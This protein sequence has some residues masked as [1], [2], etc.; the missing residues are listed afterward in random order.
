[1]KLRHVVGCAIAGV[2]VSSAIALA[3]P[4]SPVSPAAGGALPSEIARGDGGGGAGTPWHAAVGRTLTMDA[5]LG[6]ASL[7]RGSN[8]E[9]F[10]FASVTG[11]D[12]A[13]RTAPP[14]LDLA[15]VV[16]RSGSMRGVRMA[17]ATAAAV[18]AVD[19]MRDGDSVVVVAFDTRADVVVP[20]TIVDATT[21]SRIEAAVRGIR[22]GGDTC[23]SCGL[24][25]A[26]EQ[27]GAAGAGGPDRVTRVMLL[28]DGAT[29]VGVRDTAGLRA[30]AARVREQ[31]SPIT[32][33]GVDVGFDERVMGALASESNGNHYFVA[34]A[35]QLPSVFSQEFDTLVA[36][37]AR[38]AELVVEPAPGVEIE[39]VFDR[40]FR[41]E[42][43]RVVV[44]LGTFSAKD[45]KS[46][47]LKVRVP[48]D[49]DGSVPVADVKLAYR[50]LVDR[51][52]ARFDAALALQVTS[53]ED[54]QRDLDP[55]VRARVERSAT[56]RTL[57]EAN[58]LMN[59]GQF[60]EAQRRLA[61]RAADLHRAQVAAAETP[62]AAAAPA[63]DRA[64]S[65]DKDFGD[66]AAALDDANR[67]T[68]QA[69]T[70]KG[71]SRER[72][73]APKRL[74]ATLESNPFR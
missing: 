38:D 55:F 42:G 51:S 53:A 41:R 15:I 73:A 54:S 64:R 48:A 45:E 50:D 31:G 63:P 74:E 56:A 37:V 34:D 70:T 43:S 2:L 58:E 14:P 12:G 25:R 6:H 32:T 66:Q 11:V 36:S 10:L 65:F 27:L 60:D 71:D 22:L 30:L 9:T 61:G 23:I 8:G 33:I 20:R 5:R 57:A 62:A 7:A 13:A 3:L 28:S 44:P 47:L 18:G 17:N 16:D 59:A 39:Q 4:M 69:S 21:R 46:L 19:R 40:A 24:E 35:S 52:D 67:V 26:A 1:M 72:K 29:N 49:A 68:A